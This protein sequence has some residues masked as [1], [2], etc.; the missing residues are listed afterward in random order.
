MIRD[1]ALR[2]VTMPEF[3]ASEFLRVGNNF[4]NMRDSSLSG[5]KVITPGPCAVNRK[6]VTVFPEEGFLSPFLSGE[7]VFRLPLEPRRIEP[8]AGAELA[9][10]FD[11]GS[12][13]AA[14]TG[15]SAVFS[16]DPVEALSILLHER[17]VDFHRPLTARLP[18]H[19]HAVPGP[20]RQAIHK[21]LAGG[22]S[23]PGREFP[24]W[25]AENA[26]DALREFTASVIC[27]ASGSD[28]IRPGGFHGLWP[29][30]AEFAVLL[31]HDVDTA[32]SFSAAGKVSKIEAGHGIRSCWNITGRLFR[33]HSRHIDALRGTGHEIALHGWNHDNRIAFLSKPGVERRFEK[34]S[35]IALEYGIRGFRS[36]SL[37]VSDTLYESMA[38]IFSWSSS[39]IDTDFNTVTA[40]RRGACSVFPFF[41]KYLV[42]IPVTV[43]LDDKLLA[44][45]YRGGR[46]VDFVTDKVQTI[47]RAGGVA[48]IATHPEPHISGNRRMIRL[49]ETLLTKLLSMKNAWFATPSDIDCRW[50]S[51][52][53][54]N[55]K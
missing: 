53:G 45:G 17:Y 52:T 18:F 20:V 12:P 34:L 37:L 27:S 33:K 54:T 51:L 13:A 11:D 32:A 40:P 23:R 42:E 21:R 49:Y 30:G 8:P 44:L 2:M 50:R 28:N 38:E 47:A 3:T 36:P 1:L 14:V 46:F 31:T 19:Y 55:E 29:E 5:V 7:S 39:T 35:R 26:A 24:S 22:K 15:N 9:A 48:C 6:A 43:P 4:F 25:P 41:R 10:R 16:F